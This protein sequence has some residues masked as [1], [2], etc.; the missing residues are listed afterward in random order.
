MD[1]PWLFP[2]RRCQPFFLSLG[3]VNTIIGTDVV[4]G[5]FQTDVSRWLRISA[6]GFPSFANNVV[7]GYRFI[8]PGLS[9]DYVHV[10]SLSRIHYPVFYMLDR[11][12]LA[13][14][15]V[16]MG[17]VLNAFRVRVVG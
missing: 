5:T 10:Q 8:T 11:A 12:S 3:P 16:N 6:L 2:N 1:R 9:S 13:S 7:P 15:V 14:F 4:V 17:A